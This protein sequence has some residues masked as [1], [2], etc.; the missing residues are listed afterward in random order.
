MLEINEWRFYKRSRRGKRP[1]TM[2]NESSGNAIG[3]VQNSET[4]KN[5]LPR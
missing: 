1:A 2:P 3:G 5:S 4:R